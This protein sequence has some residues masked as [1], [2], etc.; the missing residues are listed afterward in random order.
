MFIPSRSLIY[1]RSD[2]TTNTRLILHFYLLSNRWMFGEKCKQHTQ[3]TMQSV[4]VIRLFEFVLPSKPLINVYTLSGCC[5]C[6]EN[7]NH[8]D[9]VLYH[10]NEKLQKTIITYCKTFNW[11]IA[12][13]THTDKN[14]A[15]LRQNVCDYAITN[16][17]AIMQNA[18]RQFLHTQLMRKSYV[19]RRTRKTPKAKH[20][21]NCDGCWF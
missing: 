5:C 13:H 4:H 21:I 3:I 6:C 8:I 17:R 19:L 2:T 1:S 10:I 18:K 9:D 14:S 12:K 15:F 11:H 16:T 20:H 7:K